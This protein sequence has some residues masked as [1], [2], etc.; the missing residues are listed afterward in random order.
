M[1]NHLPMHPWPDG[2]TRDD[3]M[4]IAEAAEVL[5]YR[6]GRA[7][8]NAVHKGRLRAYHPVIRYGALLLRADIAALKE[9]GLS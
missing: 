3:F 9:G 7:L 6:D 2:A 8:R 5:G 1:P 4:T